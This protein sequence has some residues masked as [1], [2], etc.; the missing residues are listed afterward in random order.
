MVDFHDDGVVVKELN[1]TFIGF[2]PKCARPENMSDF[3][4]ISLV[5]SFYK[6]L[7]KTLA[8]RLKK[9]IGAVIGETQSAFVK[10]RQ[11]LDSFVVAEEII[12]HWKKSKGGGL[13]VKLDFEKAYDSLDHSF[14][15]KVLKDMGFGRKWR[16]WMSC[17][18]SSLVLSVLVN[19]CP[20]RQFGIEK[21]LR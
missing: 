18:V 19:R 15:D 16:H 7:A 20:T 14:L 6:F 17:C 1:R 4:P 3:R 8:N 2:I 13:M 11:I 10:D 5:G 9:V 12:H 21:G